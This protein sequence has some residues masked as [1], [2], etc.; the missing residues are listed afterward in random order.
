LSDLGFPQYSYGVNCDKPIKLDNHLLG[1]LKASPDCQY[2]GT[3]ALEKP[4][5]HAIYVAVS[6]SD[7][8]F[9]RKRQQQRDKV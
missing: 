4:S 8:T 6:G 5:A 1:Q 9:L 2:F 3:S 7:N